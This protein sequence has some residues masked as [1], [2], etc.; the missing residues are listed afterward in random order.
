VAEIQSCWPRDLPV[1]R[2]RS[3]KGRGKSTWSCKMNAPTGCHER[4]RDRETQDK[5]RDCCGWIMRPSLAVAFFSRR[6]R[7]LHHGYPG[8]GCD[9]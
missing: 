2:T 5:I 7:P 9:L 6:G 3:N 4:D 8:R 1:I